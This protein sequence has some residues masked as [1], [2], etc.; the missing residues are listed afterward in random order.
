VALQGSAPTGI[1]A[2]MQIDPALGGSSPSATR[3]QDDDLLTELIIDPA[4]RTRS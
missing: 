2:L 1:A 4:R 3:P